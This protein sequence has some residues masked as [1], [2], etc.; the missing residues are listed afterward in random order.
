MKVLITVENKALMQLV[1]VGYLI[2][3]QGRKVT[4]FLINII[5]KVTQTLGKK[6]LMDEVASDGLISLQET[7]D[8]LITGILI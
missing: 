4:E 8:D 3:I 5:D 1:S 7:Q 2:A 6:F